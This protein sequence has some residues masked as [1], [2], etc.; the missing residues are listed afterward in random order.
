MFWYA[1]FGLHGS[2]RLPKALL[3]VKG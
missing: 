1:L 2:Y 3:V